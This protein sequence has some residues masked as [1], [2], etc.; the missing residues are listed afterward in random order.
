MPV[1]FQ[2]VLQNHII[3]V[4]AV[5]EAENVHPSVDALIQGGLPCAE[6]T[7]RT[8][9]AEAVMTASAKRGDI[10][11]GAETVLNIEQAKAVQ[12]A[13][14]GFIVSPGFSDQ[15]VE[16]CIDHSIP[17]TPG[18]CTPTDIKRALGFG[19]TLVEFFPAQAMGGLNTLKAVSA[20]FT[21]MSFIPT[22]GIDSQNLSGYLSHPKVA[23]VGGSWM[24][25]SSLIA[26]G[27]FDEIT[28]LTREAM[29]L[30]ETIHSSKVNKRRFLG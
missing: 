16:F 11:V 24:V 10:L 7:F 22:G 9:A 26:N 19:L 2:Q 20:P 28:N 23:A 17:V 30:A 4:V 15:V 13:G 1:N 25:K 5:H 21:T 12:G 3:P 29:T 14:A 27:R 18:I 6:I 8:E